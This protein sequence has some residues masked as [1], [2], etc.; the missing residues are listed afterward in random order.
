[1]RQQMLHRLTQTLNRL[2]IKAFPNPFTD[3]IQVQF[4]NPATGNHVTASVYDL[5]GR[6]VLT[7]DFGM[8]AA[9]NSLLNINTSD[10]NIKPGVYMVRLN[11]NGVPSSMWKMIKQ[12]N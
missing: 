5:T 9:G 7:K 3:K 1:M 11:I 6:T 8:M 12:K 10:Q 2:R 4:N